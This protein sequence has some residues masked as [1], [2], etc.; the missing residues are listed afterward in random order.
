MTVQ[1]GGVKYHSDSREGDARP[2]LILHLFCMT[3][4]DFL[5]GTLTLRLWL[6]HL[7]QAQPVILTN[8]KHGD[9]STALSSPVTL[10]SGPSHSHL[11]TGVLS[12]TPQ[13]TL[14]PGHLGTFQIV[15][16]CQAAKETRAPGVRRPRRGRSSFQMRYR[17]WL[18]LVSTSPLQGWVPGVKLLVGN[19]RDTG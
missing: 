14:L 15:S 11:N 8:V 10:M 2:G 19:A 4:F 18:S 3:K 13:L 6:L 7:L 1:F 5:H 12:P 16:N 17:V 9:D